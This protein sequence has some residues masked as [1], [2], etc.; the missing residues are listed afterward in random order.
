MKVLQAYLQRVSVSQG[1]ATANHA[2]SVSY[3]RIASSMVISLFAV[4]FRNQLQGGS[5]FSS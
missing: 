5:W 3:D 4:C 1:L 2:A